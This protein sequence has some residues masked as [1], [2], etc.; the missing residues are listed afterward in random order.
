MGAGD[1]IAT[2]CGQ[3]IQALLNHTCTLFFTNLHCQGN[4]LVIPFWNRF[5]G[6]D[7]SMVFGVWWLNLWG[8]MALRVCGVWWLNGLWGVVAQWCMG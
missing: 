2:H 7:G 8:V 6:C 5:L 1:H 4:G 3:L